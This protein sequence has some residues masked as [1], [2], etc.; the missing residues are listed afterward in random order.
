MAHGLPGA[1]RSRWSGGGAIRPVR[2]AWISRPICERFDRIAR[3]IPKKP[4]SM[5]VKFVSPTARSTGHRWVLAVQYSTR[6]CRRVT[7]GCTLGT[8][9]RSPQEACLRA[10]ENACSSRTRGHPGGT[11]A[12]ILTSQYQRCPVDL[13]V[14][15]T[16]SPSS[17]AVFS[18]GR[19]ADPNRSVSQIGSPDPGGFERVEWHLRR[20]IVIEWLRGGREPLQM[21][22]HPVPV[23]I[24]SKRNRAA[25]QALRAETRLSLVG[26]GRLKSVVDRRVLKSTGNE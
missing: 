22:S 1:T 13:A 12:S 26:P 15:E 3:R 21:R 5:T 4:P 9:S 14:G 10:M 2:P 7:V 8:H 17:T 19:R 6:A 16:I 20:T 25:P 23:F 18:D 11:R 24:R